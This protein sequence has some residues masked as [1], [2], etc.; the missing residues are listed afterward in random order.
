MVDSTGPAT[1]EQAKKIKERLERRIEELGHK[2]GI[3]EDRAM[4]LAIAKI[5]ELQRLEERM[6]NFQAEMECWHMQ[7][8]ELRN[9]QFNPVV[10]LRD[11]C[12]N[13]IGNL[14]AHYPR[15]KKQ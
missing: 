11:I 14:D 4:L 6:E 2:L 9:H 8:E 15:K 1:L 5:E 3:P 13:I 7:E 10:F 12:T